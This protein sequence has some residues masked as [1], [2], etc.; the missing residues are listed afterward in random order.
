MTNLF[1]MVRDSSVGIVSCYGLDPPENESQWGEIY[2]TR[3]DRPWGP[4]S[5][6]YKGNWIIPRGKVAWA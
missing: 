3:P 1:K 6:L 4:T 2:R 5:L